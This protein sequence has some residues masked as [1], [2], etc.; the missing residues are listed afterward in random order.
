MPVSDY[1]E[2]NI[3]LTAMTEENMKNWKGMKVDDKAR[4][5]FGNNI[6]TEKLRL[7]HAILDVLI[8]KRL[9]FEKDIKAKINSN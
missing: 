7:S 4:L 1:L 9:D 2:T 5:V 8:E 6:D 3:D